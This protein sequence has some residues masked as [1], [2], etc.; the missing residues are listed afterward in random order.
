MSTNCGMVFRALSGWVR[1][2][3]ERCQQALQRVAKLGQLLTLL[4][5]CGTALSRSLRQPGDV[6]DPEVDVFSS[7]ANGHSGES[8]LKIQEVSNLNLF[9]DKQ[10]VS[11]AVVRGLSHAYGGVCRDREYLPP[12]LLDL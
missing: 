1:E 11:A 6:P 10:G 5:C 9:F 12:Y 3:L 4:R 7:F 2:D 8:P